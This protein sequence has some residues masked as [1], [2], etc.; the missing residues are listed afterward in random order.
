MSKG[1]CIKCGQYSDDGLEVCGLY[2]CTPC[3]DVMRQTPNCGAFHHNYRGNYCTT[4]G[5]MLHAQ[6]MN[7]DGQVPAPVNYDYDD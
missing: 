6:R 3:R 5:Y 7:A 4:C 1:W 2:I